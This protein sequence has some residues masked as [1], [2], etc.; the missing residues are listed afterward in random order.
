MKK[1]LMLSAAAFVLAACSQPATKTYDATVLAAKEGY[2]VLAGGAMIGGERAG[3]DGAAGRELTATS[4]AEVAKVSETVADAL[5]GKKLEWLYT[6]KVKIQAGGEDA[7]WNWGTKALVNGEVKDFDGGYTIKAIYGHEDEEDKVFIK[8]QWIP[9]PKL[10][11][12]EAL[13]PATLFLPTWQEEADEH[14]FEW[15][16][17]PVVIGGEGDYTFVV[18]KYT[19]ASA[20]TVPGYGLA[21][22]K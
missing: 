22:I 19:A 14:G 1:L 13:T 20:P 6:A 15:S 10:A 3:W 12:G 9:D 5:A 16:Q 11:H 18:A 2:V 17:N 7:N 4:V 21:L 8:D